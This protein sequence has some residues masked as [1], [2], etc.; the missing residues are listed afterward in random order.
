MSGNVYEIEDSIDLDYVFTKINLLPE[1]EN[2]I[3]NTF[4]EML[5]DEINSLDEPTIFNGIK[6]LYNKYKDNKNYLKVI[7]EVVESI[8][9]G[10]ALTEILMM[11]ADDAS[12]PTPTNVINAE[13][14]TLHN[15]DK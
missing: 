7:E 1:K 3:A 11:A 10:A 6:Y 13:S 8:A 4:V 12:N 14:M 2:K 15:V 9:G 5:K